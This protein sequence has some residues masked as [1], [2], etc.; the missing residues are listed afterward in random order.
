MGVHGIFFDEAGYDFGVDRER[1]NDAVD[2]VH[3]E[4]L[5]VFM[6]AWQPAHVFYRNALPVPNGSGGVV[7]YNARELAPKLNANDYYLLESFAIQEGNYFSSTA[8]MTTTF[9]NRCR[10]AFDYRQQYNT[11]IACV[12]TL[13][14]TTANFN[15]T[16]FDEAWWLSVVYGF[17]AMGWGEFEFSTAGPNK[18]KIT[19]PTV[20]SNFGALGYSPSR[21]PTITSGIYSACSSKQSIS[22]N[23]NNHQTTTTNN[24][25]CW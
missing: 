9:N 18:D 4:G 1:Q 8:A 2:A 21:I 11:K 17:D 10:S 24:S 13:S 14:A 3:A 15:Q 23:S 22:V 7:M 12:T 16:K 6:N 19:I 20:P 5:S 25:T